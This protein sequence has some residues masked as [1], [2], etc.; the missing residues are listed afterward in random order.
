LAPIF[1]ATRSVNSTNTSAAPSNALFF[2]MVAPG[3]LWTNLMP[4][5]L[6]P[7]PALSAPTTSRNQRPFMTRKLSL[8]TT[9]LANPESAGYPYAAT[10]SRKKAPRN[11]KVRM[12]SRDEKSG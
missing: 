4:P 6:P 1:T 11:N 10:C 5:A 3:S 2:A 12:K 7:S 9:F 8:S